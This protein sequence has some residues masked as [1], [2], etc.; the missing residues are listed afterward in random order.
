ME[1]LFFDLQP[2][3]GEKVKEAEERLHL[4]STKESKLIR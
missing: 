1:Q 3:G 4:F 2:C